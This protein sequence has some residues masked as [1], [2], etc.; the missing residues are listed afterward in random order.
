LSYVFNHYNGSQPFGEVLKKAHQL[1]LTEPD[2]REDLSGIDVGRKLLILARYM[3]WKIN[4]GDIPVENLVPPELRSGSFSDEFFN[5]FQRYESF[6]QEKLE[7][8][9]RENKVLRYVG[10][11][12]VAT[13]TASAQLEEI[14]NDHPLALSCYADNI[15]SFTTHHY[16]NAPLVIRGPG[17]GV[18]CT[19]MGVFSDILEL[20]VH[21][22]K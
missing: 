14:P 17:A 4:L 1:Q 15:I 22:P 9:Q 7:R 12:D 6:I 13:H 16:R 21:L 2:P 18:E 10:S 3:G 19:A 20:I 11:I 5:D 8:C